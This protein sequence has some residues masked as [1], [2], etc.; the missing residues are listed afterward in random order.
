MT[1]TF[2]AATTFSWIVANYLPLFIIC[3]VLALLF[4]IFRL[5]GVTAKLVWRILI[6]CIAG[7]AMLLLFNVVFFW[8]LKMDFF[9]IR[10]TWGNSLI[11]GVF[12]VP[13]VIFLLIMKYVIP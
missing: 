11:A 10:P 5:A 7:A 13:G 9:Y 3:A 2:L 8:I 6:N 4:I 12:G 1:N